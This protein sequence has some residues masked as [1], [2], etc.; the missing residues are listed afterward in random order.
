MLLKFK[1]IDIYSRSLDCF[2]LAK[3]C[4]FQILKLHWLTFVPILIVHIINTMTK[5][6]FL[7]GFDA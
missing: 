3:G 5:E 7:F 1:Q 6:A 4:V 2:F